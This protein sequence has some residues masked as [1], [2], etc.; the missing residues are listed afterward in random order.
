MIICRENLHHAQ[1]LQ[2]QAHNKG[3]KPRRYTPSDKIW[4]NSKYIKN[5]RNRKLK[6]KFFRPFRVLY[7]VRKQA[8]KLKLLKRWK[9]HDIF[10]MSLLEQN[11]TRK[12]R[13]DKRVTELELKASDSKE[14]E[15]EAI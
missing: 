7:Q 9:M 1:E 3:V 10:Q 14:Y 8:Y 15:I 4:L 12:E 6:A 5:K 2:K 13:A 11:T